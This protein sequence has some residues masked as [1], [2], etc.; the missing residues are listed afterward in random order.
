VAVAGHS[1]ARAAGVAGFLFTISR[2]D[3]VAAAGPVRV[4]VDYGRFASAF[5]GG[6][7]SRLTLVAMPGCALSTPAVPACRTQRPVHA[8]NDFA[9]R[10]LTAQVSVP[11]AG[12]GPGMV[13]AAAS[14]TSG[15]TGD[16]KGTSL[17]PSSMWQVG[18][19]SGDFTWSYPLRVPPPIGGTAPSLALAYDSGSIDGETAQTNSQPGQAGEGFSLAGGG[20]IE[21]KYANCADHVKDS[22]NATGQKNKTGDLCWD[23]DNAYLNLGGRTTPIIQDTTGAWRLAADDGSTVQQLTGAANGAYQGQY[24]EVITPDGT[25]YIFGQNQLPGWASGDQATNSAWTVPVVGL[26]SGD[27]CHSSSYASAVCPNMAWRWNLDL[28][29]DP[30]GNATEYFYNPQTSYYSFDSYVDSSGTLH[31][32][33]KTKYTT[34]GTLASI[35]Y[36]SQMPNVY[37]QQPMRVVF[38]Y[39]DR[40]TSSNQ[41]TCDATHNG[42]YWPDTPWDLYCSSSDACTGS[43]HEAPSFFD[44]QMLTSVDT[45]VWEGSGPGYVKVDTWTLGYA[46]L[47][48]EVNSDLFLSS[49]KH[50]GDVGGSKSAGTVTFAPNPLIN[51]VPDNTYPAMTRYRIASI[52]TETGAR[53]TVTYNPADC[54]SSRPNPSSDTLACFQQYW[55]PDDIGGQIVPSWFYKY[56]VAEVDVSDTTG[57]N[58]DM[59][60]YYTYNNG[61]PGGAAWHYDTDIDLVLPKY[62][63]YSQWRGYQHVTVITGSPSGTQSQADYT[64]FRGMDGDPI[65]PGNQ[66][67]ASATV[68]DSRGVSF[69]DSPRANGF[70]LEK[71]TDNG[72]GGAMVSDQ[73]N[74]PWLSPA[75]ATSASQPWGGT[76]TAVLEGTAR[77]DTYAPVVSGTRHTEVTS[78]FDNATGLVTQTDDMG[79]VSVPAQELCTSY[80]YAQNTAVNVNMLDYPSEVKVTA[81]ACGASSPPLVSDTRYLYDGGAFGAAP[82]SGNVTETDVYSSGD[83]GVADHWVQQSRAKYDTYGRLTSTEDAGNNT[84]KISYTSSYGAGQATTQTVVTDPLSHIITTDIQPEWGLPA[85]TIDASGQRTDYAYDPL[86]RLT[87]VWLP[88]QTGK[89]RTCATG[90]SYPACDGSANYT[91]A[92]S[93]LASV[94]SSVT[95]GR[96]INAASGLYVSSYALFDSLLRPRQAQAP[97]E[98]ISGGAEVTD[99]FYDSRGNTVIHNGPYPVSAA[100]STS[101]FHT[102]PESSIPNETASSYD[103]AGRLIEQDLDSLG[104]LQ[105]NTS[106]AYPGTDAITVTPPAGG[107]ATTTYTD[108]RGRTTDIYQYRSATPPAAP[109][110]AGTGS[111]SGSSGWDHT[112][113]TYAPAG[114]LTGITDPTGNTW[115]YGYDLLGRQITATAPDT[116]T[117]TSTYNDLSQLTSVTDARNKTI[118]YTYDADGRK[119]TEYDTTGGV[120]PSGSNE[121]AAWTY[122]TATLNDPTLPTGSEAVGQ[123][124]TATAYTGGTS[125]QAYAETTNS[126]DPAYHPTSTTYSIPSNGITGKL[127]GSYTVTAA[128]NVDGTLASQGYPAGGGLNAETVY[129]NYDN[130]GSPSSTA[131]S[132]SAYV[133][134]SFY[135]PDYQPAEF[136]LGTATSAKWSRMLYSYDP[137]TARLTEIRIQEEAANW[138]NATD[139]S[140][141]YDNAGNVTKISDTVASDTQCLKYDYAQRLTAAW[142][143]T[144]TACP[145]TPP[146]ASGIGGP[147]PYQQKLTYDT[148]GA[149][150]ITDSNLI[151]P[152][153][154]TDTA[155]TY[156]APGTAQPHA[157]TSATTTING[158]ATT[159]PSTYTPAGQLHTT[160]TGAT[161]QT[162][163]WNTAGKL[164]TASDGSGDSTAYRY[165][166]AGNLL[167]RQDNTTATLYLPGQ[168]LSATGSTVTATRYYTHAGQTIAARTPTGL[169]WLIGDPHG[170]DT[171]AI[172]TTN[173]NPATNLTQRHYTPFGAPRGTAPASWPGDH[174][175]AGG[176]ADALTGLTNLGAREYNPAT[177]LFLS[178]DP[179]LTPDTPQDLNPYAYAQDNPA[180]HA[181]PTGL[182]LPGGTQCGILPSEPCQGGGSGGSGGG[183]GGSSGRGGT[184]GGSGYTYGGS[185]GMAIGHLGIVPPH[186]VQI[187][188]Y[189]MAHQTTCAYSFGQCLLS[190]GAGITDTAVGLSD[191]SPAGLLDWALTGKTPSQQFTGQATSAGVPTG[192]GSAY[193]AG[194]LTGIL[195]LAAGPGALARA[196]EDIATAAQDAA[197][198]GQRVFRVWGRDPGSPDLA[199][200]QSGPWGSS[201][202]RVD[203]GSVLKYRDVA[204]L[205]DEANLGRFVSEGILRDP[206]GVEATTATP[207]GSNLGGLDELIIPNPEAQIELQGVYGVNPPF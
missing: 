67:F 95:T 37:A 196:P 159:S 22:S 54:G 119:T 90:E 190:F 93:L 165:D 71:I 10:S 177:T 174:G 12:T 13:L 101:L 35:V 62:K 76:L 87:S 80:S 122:D 78:T 18:L 179:I 116:G 24:W 135:F 112:G 125:G 175:F 202:T 39:S 146:G 104:V 118:S 77:S 187:M 151:T 14:S 16:F 145:V 153:T 137:A 86:G 1:A 43:G 142:A 32:G 48:A 2:A 81:G 29:I 149:G 131:S 69:T 58:P 89:H 172:D 21:R 195:A 132:L 157:A 57:G 130:L 30:N 31:N 66:G 201:W 191:L 114:Q 55:A 133:E 103:G 20:F 168:E 40:C 113:H 193:F 60:T 84:T 194:Q 59:P 34:G 44:T 8:V 96:L 186:A 182:M 203:P 11:A 180:T 102:P 106:Y 176:A 173:N 5:G 98:G 72:P 17:A 47:S 45:E 198:S 70:L 85:D 79:D 166:A 99:T 144:A 127:S 171:A 26:K 164:A 52:T 91:Y 169:T 148:G 51:R 74:R 204:G 139:T 167:L 123:L 15:G 63:S 19:Q 126:Y 41:S 129:H 53:I 92:Y 33:T 124:A 141:G 94:P 205:P 109:P 28:V 65:E 160:G 108:A 170:T 46:W 88:G 68:T 23:G 206:T 189:Q 97:A 25:Q 82:T 155:L 184:G 200:S 100:P 199:R 121:L 181:D 3:G 134:Q 64:F 107:T 156:P 117:T 185:L 162:L 49:I 207:I 110:A 178:P 115:A 138:A 143:Q 9:G 75:T 163:T 183:Y 61:N 6:F 154:T 4:R 7:G 136:D 111:S 128:Y 73:I 38:G 42:T 50:T 197:T 188:Q 27:P 152:G 161:A 56:T 147:A 150:N 140:Y 120:T 105:W 158:T 36:G 192:R 83:P